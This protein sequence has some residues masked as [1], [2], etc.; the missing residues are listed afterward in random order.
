MWWG[1]AR[2]ASVAEAMARVGPCGRGMREE[3]DCTSTLSHMDA[4][5]QRRGG[6]E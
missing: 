6:A 4:V 5:K 3:S 2:Q 1:V